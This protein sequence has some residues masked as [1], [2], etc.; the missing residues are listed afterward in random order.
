MKKTG[1]RLALNWGVYPADLKICNSTDE[2]LNLSVERAKEF[3]DLEEGDKLIITG[4]FPNT[5]E[6]RTTNLMKIEVID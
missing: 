3:M 1:R 5:D 2:V 4:G 6:N